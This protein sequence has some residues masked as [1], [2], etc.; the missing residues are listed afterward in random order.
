MADISMCTDADCPS[1][2][3]CYR[4]TAVPNEHWQSYTAFCRE[5]D[6]CPDYLPDRWAEAE[7]V[8]NG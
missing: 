4:Q 8:S 1:R 2:A 3:H 7:E 6:R 5:G